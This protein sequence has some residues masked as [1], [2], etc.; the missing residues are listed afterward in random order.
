MEPLTGRV[1]DQRVIHMVEV[2]QDPLD[3]PKFRHLKVPAAF[4]DDPVPILH[5]PPRKVTVQDQQD[6]KIPP[7][8]S[9][10]KNAR[11]YTI[12]LDK[13]LAADG[14]GLQQTVVND[15]FATFAEALQVAES[16]MRE[17]VELRNSIVRQQKE[18]ERLS[19]EEMLR[20]RA[21]EVRQQHEDR[22]RIESASFFLFFWGKSQRKPGGTRGEARTRPAAREAAARG[23][24]GSAATRAGPADAGGARAGARHQRENRAGAGGGG[25]QQRRDVRFEAVRS[26]RGHGERHG[27]R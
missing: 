9:N 4:N 21:L 6:W 27:C 7:C 3:P 16:K 22:H 14:R 1:L 26:E 19:Q 13:R 15:R 23:G 11:G 25:E 18:K 2:E 8:I 10:W 20:R 5:S 17:E 12:P 24:A